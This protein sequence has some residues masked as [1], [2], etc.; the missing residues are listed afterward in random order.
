MPNGDVVTGCSDGV[1]R[2]FSTAEERWV[3]ADEL[4]QYDEDVAK[5]AL[6]S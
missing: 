5:Q 2:V 4:R 6:P 3:S 1:I